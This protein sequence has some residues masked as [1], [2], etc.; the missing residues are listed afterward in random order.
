[1]YWKAK[2]KHTLGEQRT[3][4]R[5]GDLIVVPRNVPHRLL[6]VGGAPA[7][8]YIVFS[9]PEREFVPVEHPAL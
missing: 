8:C 6:N 1:M 4:L 2:S 3:T 9:S 5:A 7:R